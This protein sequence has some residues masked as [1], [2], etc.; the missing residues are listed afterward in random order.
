MASETSIRPPIKFYPMQAPEMTSGSDVA[1]N[2]KEVTV[3]GKTFLITVINLLNSS[4][5]VFASGEQPRWDGSLWPGLDSDPV[6]NEWQ[7]IG[8]VGKERLK[9]KDWGDLNRV[10]YDFDGATDVGRTIADA[11]P[12]GSAALDFSALWTS[13]RELLDT[14]KSFGKNLSDNTYPTD[15]PGQLAFLLGLVETKRR[16]VLGLKALG[17]DPYAPNADGS[18]DRFNAAFN[19]ISLQESGALNIQILQNYTS[20]MQAVAAKFNALASDPTVN[21]VIL[22]GAQASYTGQM[23]DLQK[24]INEL[25]QPLSTEEQ[26]PE[27]K[28]AIRGAFGQ[29][30]S[31]P[32][33]QVVGILGMNSAFRG[34]NKSNQNR[35][36]R[37]KS[38]AQETDLA[39]MQ[40]QGKR[41]SRIKAE[42]MQAEQRAAQQRTEASRQA[43]HKPAAKP[44]K[45]G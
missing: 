15:G 44:K 17:I 11:V 10:D 6:E 18:V 28:T 2:G 33:G 45:G 35:Y 42:E 43:A 5:K 19:G 8:Y 14:H 38:D 12:A 16:W 1:G 7:S 36:E 3:Q 31:K 21:G 24:I 27:L 34:I 30:L 23:A 22:P 40:S 4:A 26:S 13:L 39:E 9:A 41:H 25:K 29:A 32:I 37:L 20:I